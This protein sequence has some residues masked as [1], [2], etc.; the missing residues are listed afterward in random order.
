MV[1]VWA[2][3]GVRWANMKEHKMVKNSP[4]LGGAPPAGVP[5][6]PEPGD[7]GAPTSPSPEPSFSDKMLSQAQ[8][9][10]D[11]VKKVYAQLGRIRKG[12]DALVAK[13]D[14]VVSDDVLD[15]MADLVAHGADPKVLA[16][17]IAGNTQAGVGPMPPSGE[18]LAGWLRNAETGIVA[19]AEAKLR[20]AMALAQHQLGVA[21]VHKIV[22]EHAKAQA[23]QALAAPPS[24]SPALAASP[25]PSPQAFA[26]PAPSPLLQ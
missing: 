4:L 14:A 3:V 2:Q 8:G 1:A 21:A 12:L 25:T 17:M 9:R 24:A 10:F 6:V 23:A 22:G 7:P 11:A 18:P 5:T 19:P 20:P 15:E 13:G 16:A 26:Q